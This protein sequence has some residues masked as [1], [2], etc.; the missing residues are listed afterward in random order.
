PNANQKMC[1]FNTA[2][3]GNQCKVDPY[4]NACGNGIVYTSAC[5]TPTVQ[6]GKS[7][8]SPT[9]IKNDPNDDYGQYDQT[10]QAQWVQKLISRYGQGNQGGVSIWSLDNEP[11]WWDSTHLDIHPNPY[12]Y[13][14][15]LS[16]D[17]TYAAAIKAADPT[18]LV[19][20]P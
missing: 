10:F 14:E 7:P 6:D 17:T 13:D 9:Y 18:A 3:Y 11:I 5:G 2:K 12:T 8:S 16:L 4:W 19:T 15:N 20:G 1:S